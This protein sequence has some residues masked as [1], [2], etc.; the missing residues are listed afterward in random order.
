M[1]AV[2]YFRERRR[3]RAVEQYVWSY[4]EHP[5]SDEEL[6]ATDAFLGDVRATD[7]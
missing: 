6:Q 1:A 2:S 5:E 4:S 3:K 7:E